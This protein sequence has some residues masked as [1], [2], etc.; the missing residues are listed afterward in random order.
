VLSHQ[1]FDCIGV[2]SREANTMPSIFTEWAYTTKAAN[3]DWE[4]NSLFTV[5]ERL[6]NLS[7]LSPT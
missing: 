6:A 4:V 7:N 5:G 2:F 3:A 1:T